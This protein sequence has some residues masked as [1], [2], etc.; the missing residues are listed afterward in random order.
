MFR[1]SLWIDQA[2]DGL[3]F[4]RDG[5]IY[6]N[7]GYRMIKNKQLSGAQHSHVVRG[8]SGATAIDKKVSFTLPSLVRLCLI[9]FHFLLS[10]HPIFCSFRFRFAEPQTC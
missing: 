6:A 2:E 7:H 1:A 4:S 3:Q 5:V 8:G 9:T 10:L